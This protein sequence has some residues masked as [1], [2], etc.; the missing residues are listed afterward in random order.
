[1]ETKKGSW[2]YLSSW[3]IFCFA[4]MQVDTNRRGDNDNHKLHDFHCSW[5]LILWKWIR[6]L[7][8]RSVSYWFIL[9]WNKHFASNRTMKKKNKNKKKTRRGQERKSRSPHHRTIPRRWIKDLLQVTAGYSPVHRSA[10]ESE[11][12]T[13]IYFFNPAAEVIQNMNFEICI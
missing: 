9:L 13:C 3:F 11:C 6:E 5:I 2:S 8:K 7:M 12:E 4:V 1:M 10:V